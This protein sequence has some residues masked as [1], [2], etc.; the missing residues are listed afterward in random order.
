M[1]DGDGRT[2]MS[3]AGFLPRFVEKSSRRMYKEGKVGW[4]GE[5]EDRENGELE[6][7]V[8]CLTLGF[9]TNSALAPGPASRYGPCRDSN[10][11]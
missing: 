3:V 11:V 4:V 8:P 7:P 2:G 6:G 9:R 1:P 5:G 10:V